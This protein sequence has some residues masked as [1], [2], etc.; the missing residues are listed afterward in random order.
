[1]NRY[2]EREKTN[3]HWVHLTVGE[4]RDM[5]INAHLQGGIG[6][7]SVGRTI[8]VDATDFAKVNYE[9]LLKTAEEFILD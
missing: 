9:A 4:D 8:C 2:A 6:E 7:V 3:R 5:F 1:M